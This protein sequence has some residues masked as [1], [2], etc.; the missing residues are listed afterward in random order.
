[1]TEQEREV[2]I[3]NL[4]YRIGESW[5]NGAKHF[6]S[7]WPQE[8]AGCIQTAVERLQARQNWMNDFRST[9]RTYS[10]QNPDLFR[11]VLRE[12]VQEL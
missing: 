2:K 1:M 7:Q 5:P 11:Q 9:L 10:E 6:I 4:M 8:N 12:F 3:H